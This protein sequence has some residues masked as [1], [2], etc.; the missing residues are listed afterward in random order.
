MDDNTHP[1]IEPV[2]GRLLHYLVLVGFLFLGISFLVYAFGLLPSYMDA[3]RVPEV[4]HLPA[5][6]AVAETQRP[7]FWT[8]LTN[9][10]RGDLL[11][12]GSLA[13]LSATTPVG[14]LVLISLFL[15]RRDFAYAAMVAAQVAVLLLAAS[16]IIGGH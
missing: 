9:L 13:V 6:E 11:S 7:A 5:D 3:H 12:L 14:F 4:W 2:Y 10:D 16:G 15:R 1:D 8:W